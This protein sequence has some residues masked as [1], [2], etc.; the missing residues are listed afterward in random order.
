MISARDLTKLY[1]TVPAL[2]HVS[3]D[4]DRAQIFGVI[5]HN[6][7]GKT[8]LLKILAG[9]IE[10]TSGELVVD[11]TDILKEPD[12]MKQMIGYLPEESRLYETMKVDE[13]LTFF[14]EIY[15]MDRSS[16]R[17]R[18]KE[19]LD[20]LSLQP[21]G[22]KMGEFSKG[23]KRKAAI[24]RSLMHNPSVLIYD[25][26]TS[27]LDPMTSR[28]IVDFLRELRD[29]GKTI[30]LSAHNLYQ[31]EAICDKILILRRGERIAFGS[32]HELREM[33]GSIYYS[34]YFTV[35]DIAKVE[36]L[37][38]Y[39]LDGGYYRAKATSVDEMGRIS[40]AIVNA[41][42]SV[43]RIESHYPSL[44]EMLVKIGA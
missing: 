32:M 36:G 8:T 23:M 22:K 39:V 18:S 4:L 29:Q 33:F 31:V 34:I 17:A 20:W 3:F 16:I 30:I 14:G 19:L 44:E 24:A 7:A 21:N 41:G 6:G 26:A 10:P 42:G 9:L 35:S 5:G 27:G 1:G 28:H 11:G 15:G 25:E 37:T 13:Y 38:S 43:E 2:D 40:N 12:G